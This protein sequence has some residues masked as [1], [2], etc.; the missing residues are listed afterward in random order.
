M[1]MLRITGCSNSSYWYADKI[2]AVVPFISLDGGEWV[3]REPSGYVNII[4]VHE[5]ELVDVTPT[6]PGPP[7]TP[8][9]PSI[10]EPVTVVISFPSQAAADEAVPH[11]GSD[12]DKFVRDWLSARTYGGHLVG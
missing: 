11:L 7:E 4:K 1:Q 3:T 8:P 10:F 9:H 12:L 6:E 2:G 5:A